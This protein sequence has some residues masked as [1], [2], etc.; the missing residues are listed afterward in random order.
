MAIKV[1]INGAGG[2]MGQAAVDTISKES[3]LELVG[4]AHRGDDLMAMI[5]ASRAEVV[6]D[7]TA[8]SAVYENVTTIIA[9]NAHPVIGTSGLM[10][11]QV[12]ELQQRCAEKQLG[13]IIA[14]NFSIGAVLMMR[15]AQM[16]APYFSQV[17]IIE[18]HHTGKEDAPS[19]TAIKTAE[20]I[21]SAREKA[22]AP[23]SSVR[24]IIPGSRGALVNNVP[25][26][27]LRI[28]GVVATQEVIFGG[29][30]ETLSIKDAAINRDAYMPGICFACR[31]VV[32]LKELIY[33]L[34]QLL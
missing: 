19:G 22:A 11:Q 21:A 4:Q 13:G 7:L 26:H 31:K 33:G 23:K 25:I 16:A 6:L 3:D 8:A 18:M 5:K 28:P 34:D 30:G 27:A 14:P 20:M 12:K 1:L 9:A 24:E 29:Q 10:P 15:F 17:E 2:R 32:S